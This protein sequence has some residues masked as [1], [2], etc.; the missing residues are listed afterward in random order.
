MRYS[1]QL[2]TL[3]KKLDNNESTAVAFNYRSKAFDSISHQI[4]LQKLMMLKLD[5]NVMSRMETFSTNRQ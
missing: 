2:K 3:E 1:M 5:D 4:L